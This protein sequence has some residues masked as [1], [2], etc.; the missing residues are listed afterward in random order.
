MHNLI[1]PFTVLHLRHVPQ[2]RRRRVFSAAVEV[3]FVYNSLVIQRHPHPPSRIPFLIVPFQSPFLH[4]LNQAH[5]ACGCLHGVKLSYASYACRACGCLHGV[6]LSYTSYACTV[7]VQYVA[8][9]MELNCAVQMGTDTD[10][11]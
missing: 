3:V 5:R 6:K 8:V 2:S 4:H 11:L 1:H 7:H 9:Y 10:Y